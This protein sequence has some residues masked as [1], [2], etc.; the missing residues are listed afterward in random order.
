MIG[1]VLYDLMVNDSDIS[2]LVGDR[3]YPS[4][5]KED[6]PKPYIVYE[7]TDETPTDDK[8]G[9][10]TLDESFYDIMVFTD[11]IDQLEVLGLYIRNILDRFSGTNS[12][13]DVDKIIYEEEVN[14]YND[15]DRLYGKQIRYRIRFFTI[16][17]NLAQPTNLTAVSA[18]T[19]QINLSWDDNA[20]D[21]TGYEVW[22]SLDQISW[23]LVTTTAAE[24]TSYN[25]TGLTA[26]TVY[27]Y[28]I[29]PVNAIGGGYW[30]LVVA[31]KTTSAATPSGITYQRPIDTGAE[32]QYALYDAK[33]QIDNGTY[34]YTPPSFPDSYAL[35]DYTSAAP[36][37][38]LLN[39]NAF[40][41]KNRFTDEFGTQVYAS[42]YVIDH[43]AGL[44]WKKTAET[45][46]QWSTALSNANSKTFNSFS[47]W[48]VPTI[49]EYESIFYYEATKTGGTLLLNYS[50]W[51]N[52][53]NANYWTADT[54]VLNSLNAYQMDTD[55]RDSFT[56]KTGS[57]SYYIVRNHYT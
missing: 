15:E 8:D 20:T 21:E 43:L 25:N 37:I 14:E 45:G 39:N 33:W 13:W 51:N 31:E 17:Q 18:S 10:S 27:Y 12:G 42:G 47:D 11:D 55:G 26:N 44:G 49:K 6:V 36:F 28:R 5:A 24:A 1:K 57:L 50:P 32:T 29:R 2:G 19:T 56:A 7:K 35:L 22:R 40:G 46:A 4:L 53:S 48:R 34:T 16:Y 9:K 52:S 38:T 54:S 30:S 41:N 3:I 23:T